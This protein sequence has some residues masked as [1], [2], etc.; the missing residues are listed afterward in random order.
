LILFKNADQRVEFLESYDSS[1]STTVTR[2]R[3]ISQNGLDW[4]LFSDSGNGYGFV[5]TVA[6]FDAL[7]VGVTLKKGIGSNFV[8]LKLQNVLITK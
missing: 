6:E 2:W 1:I 7:K 8:P 5:D 3:A 4:D